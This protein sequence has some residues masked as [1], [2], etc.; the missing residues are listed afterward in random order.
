MLRCILIFITII[1][2]GLGASAQINRTRE[3]PIPRKLTSIEHT[4]SSAKLAE[5][6]RI[7]PVRVHLLRNSEAAAAVTILK[8]EDIERIFRKANGI[9][10][11]GGIHLWVE[12]IVVEKPAKVTGFEHEKSL[13]TSALQPL[14]PEE[15]RKDPMYHV[16]YINSMGP[17]GIFMGRDAIF[18]KETAILHPVAGGIDEPLPRVTAHELGH[19]MGLPHRQAVINLMA[20]GTTGTGLNEAEIEIVHNTVDKI[21]WVGKPADFLKKTDELAASGKKALAISRYNTLLELPGNAQIK[22]DAKAHL[23]KVNK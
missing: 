20:S 6:F 3:T 13:P 8:K 19:G 23:A 7:V 17:N 9:W 12:S 1:A 4:E 18:V 2:S 22:A 11:L 16:Y 5:D 21:S 10:H 15:S 14:R